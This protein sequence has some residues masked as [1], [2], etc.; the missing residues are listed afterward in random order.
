M[1]FLEVLKVILL[2]IIEGITEWLPVSSSGHILLFD[3]LFPMNCSP[4]FKEV[5][6]YVVQLGAI[7]AVIILFFEKLF[8][9]GIKKQ[10]L[11]LAENANKIDET[12]ETEETQTA[13]KRKFFI[14]KD[15]FNL[16]GKV[17]VAC[18]PAAI[19]GVL[20][21]MPDHPLIIAIALIVYG[22]AFIAMEFF[23]KNR[24][25]KVQTTDGI[26]YKHA[27]IIGLCQVLS[28]IPGTS[29]SGVT[30]LAAL[31]L[32]ISRPAGAEFTFFLA[33]P[34][35]V[36][37]SF[38]KLLKYGFAFSAAEF[39]YLAIGVLVAFVVS[40]A[41]IKLLMNFVRKHDF[42]VFGWYRIVLGV[43]VIILIVCSVMPAFGN[44]A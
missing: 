8:P 37:A 11:P 28:I 40:L 33:V 17:I 14:K 12:N 30:I 39:G 4:E 20:F 16:W 5:F 27:L 41:C 25:F 24:E 35:M 3:A 36:G 22:V 7:L 34:V 32:G 29:R 43:I 15:V 13:V 38:L 42:T 19:V 9:F 23:N 6:L 44:V 31:L 26:T 18:A 2:G 10:E 21:D 1:Q